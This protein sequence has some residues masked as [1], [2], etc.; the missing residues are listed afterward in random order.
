LHTADD[1]EELLGETLDL[2]AQHLQA[3]ASALYVAA[4]AIRC[5]WLRVDG[6]CVRGD[7][8]VPDRWRDRLPTTITVCDA[9]E[10]VGGEIVIDV[11]ICLENELVGLFTFRIAAE[12]PSA[13][14]LAL[15]QALANQ[16]AIGMKL[17]RLARDAR[18]A[19]VGAAVAEERNRLAR[20]IHDT[21]AQGLAAIIRQLDTAMIAT[22]S[23]AEH[24][25]LA[26]MI[27]RD[28]LVEAR[29]SIR[30]LRPSALDGRCFDTAVRELVERVERMA[31]CPI[32]VAVN[33][34]RA[35][36]P[37]EV[38]DELYRIT[39]EALT[40]ALKHA[41]AHSIEIDVAYDDPGVRIIVRDD[42]AGFDASV[43]RGGI[44]MSSMR[45][46]AARIGAALTVATEPGTGTEVLVYWAGP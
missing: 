38:E 33:G 13:E 18:A 27:A 30:A 17:A 3:G 41:S 36:L 40:N 5:L 23:A 1:L 10:G 21:I 42:G 39:Q 12:R 7:L 24:V 25:T 32:R 19:V 28:S 45:E 4:P 44:G 15:L 14:D 11:P 37:S 35:D 43:Q 26:A 34:S 22:G 6:R 9:R 46:R 8:A 2:L 31:A 16:A 20:E 29:R